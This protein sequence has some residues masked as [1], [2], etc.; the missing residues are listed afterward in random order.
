MRL[1]PLLTECLGYRNGEMMTK[2]PSHTRRMRVITDNV[3]R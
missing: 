1:Q 3:V 2:I